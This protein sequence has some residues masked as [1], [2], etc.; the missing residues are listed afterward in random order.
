MFVEYNGIKSDRKNIT[1]GVPQGSILGPLLFLIYIND[2]SD[3]SNKLFSL[4]F[5]DDSNMFI[6]GKNINDLMKTMNDELN[7]VIEWLN[8]NKLSLNLKKTHYMIFRKR[9]E[10]IL[11]GTDLVMNGRVIE[12]ASKLNS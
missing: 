12:M 7:N 6:R 9:R 2:L 10:K 11:V 4:L 3:V 5:A 1:C 8:V